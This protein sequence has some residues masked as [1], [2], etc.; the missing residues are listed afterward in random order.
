MWYNIDKITLKCLIYF[1]MGVN[2]Y[3]FLYNV[4]KIVWFVLEIVFFAFDSFEI[5]MFIKKN[6]NEKKGKMKTIVFLFICTVICIILYSTK[7]NLIKM[8]KVT[9]NTYANAIQTLNENGINYKT[10][11]IVSDFINTIVSSQSIEEGEIINKRK[12]TVILYIDSIDNEERNSVTFLQN[13]ENTN[14]NEN[15]TPD[16]SEN[17]KVFSTEKTL[18]N[19]LEN[20]TF[21]SE[22][23]REENLE[24]ITSVSETEVA[25]Q[26]LNYNCENEPNND[27]P[28][29]TPINVNQ[30]IEG[31]LESKNDE[32]FYIFN[33]T[34]K[35]KLS[36]VFT[37]EKF[38]SS[39]VYWKF[40]IY[41][42]NSEK[43]DT[44]DVSG[45]ISETTSNSIRLPAGK[46]YCKIN[47]YNYEYIKYTFNINYQNEYNNYETENNNDFPQ[48]TEIKV[49]QTYIGNIQDKYDKDY[50]KFEIFQKGKISISFNHEQFDNFYDYWEINLISEESNILNFNS[51]GSTSSLTSDVVRLPIGTYYIKIAPYNFNNTDYNFSI[52][53]NEENEFF[54]DEPNND[55]KFA[56]NIELET[57][58]TGNIQSKK[59]VDFYEINIT[60]DNTNIEFY[61]IHEI[62]DNNYSYWN[63]YFLDTNG[64]R[65]NFSDE[66]NKNFPYLSIYG[67]TQKTKFYINNIN[68]GKYYLKICPE[69][70]K[71]TDYSFFLTK[72]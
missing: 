20:T 39:Y 52:N 14:S 2:M 31:I 66:N 19:E 22:T 24:T 44:F 59:D 53:Y 33:I 23:E 6:S 63:V 60:E 50:F 27:F 56:T 11:N 70:Y 51:T 34:Q 29:A 16:N 38:D 5:I 62:T 7:D 47:S 28:T 4:P 10:D 26:S 3:S 21:I 41:D 72:V 69:N 15:T 49:N 67:C 71:N 1:R 68:C 17:T 64:N 61:F 36:I 25:F 32:D 43:I 12:D 55:Y 40:N 46:Y 37:H 54:E 65:L 42:S 9:P 48:A 18:E 45:N 8:P 57:E 35:G 13:Q 58:Y 30:S